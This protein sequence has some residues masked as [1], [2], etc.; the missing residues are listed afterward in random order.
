[1]FHRFPTWWR[2]LSVVLLSLATVTWPSAAH[3]ATTPS[4]TL[5]HQDA[6]AVLT[7]GGT[8]RFSV[9]LKLAVPGRGAVAQLTLFPRIVTRSEITPIISGAGVTGPPTAT[10]GNFTLRCNPRQPITFTIALYTHR[11]G[12]QVSPCTSHF[13]RLRL[14]CV[15]TSCDGVY[16]LS[17]TVTSG[18]TTSTKWSLVA[19][20]ASPVNQPLQLNWITTLDPLSW[21]HG[22]A[23]TVLLEALARRRMLPLTLTADY[24]TLAKVLA[25]TTPAAVAWRG[26]LVK[27]L[28][29]PL[30]RIVVA[31]PDNIDFGGLA[32]NGLTTQVTQQLSLTSQLLATLTGRFVDSPVV[33]SGTPSLGSLNALARTGVGEVVLP[34]S[35]LTVAPSSTLNWGAPFHIE[36]APSLTA[37]S[38]DQGL[39]QLTTDTSI[40]PGRRATI[41]LALL[42]FLHFEAPNAP[43]LRTVVVQSP[44]ALTS[45]SYVNDLFNGLH[46]DPFVSASSLVPSF[47]SSLVATNGAPAIRTI[48]SPSNPGWSSRNVATLLTLIGA[49]TS[50]SQAVTSPSVSYAL[51]VAVAESE[52]V[53]SSSRRQSA[54]TY[55]NSVLT[56]QLNQFSIDPSTITLAGSGTAL[57]I[58]VLSR[59]PYT[60]NAVVQ[61]TTNG[62]GLDRGK[63]FA[64]RLNSSTTSLRIT[65]AKSDVGNAT[66]QVVLATPNGQIV[67]ARAAIQVRVTATSVVG[68]LLTFASLLVLAVWWWRTNRRPA[69]GRHA[70]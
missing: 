12:R 25:A 67:L 59:A 3:A 22:Q 16:P 62:F 29:S 24:E 7:S 5:V 30:H 61:L 48:T 54:L 32:H 27:A 55:A 65:T 68:Y 2:A 18:T 20:Q 46:H 52:I 19:V 33:L 49:A 57:P 21:R 47:D 38:T 28:A 23:T 11:P 31:P 14:P 56:Q 44:A 6:V 45:V 15:A 40:E 4:F 13:A 66:L 37:L 69:K 35:T 70:R 1:M 17:Y 43:A 58:T 42:A 8:S 51:R 34:E 50:Y 64:I 39:S 41:T 60:V 63:N 9:T 10:T 26:A 36:G 53:G